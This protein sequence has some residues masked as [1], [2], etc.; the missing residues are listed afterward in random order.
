[1]HPQYE[2]WLLCPCGCLALSVNSTRP[3]AGQPHTLLCRASW[4][5][6][7]CSAL[8]ANGS[9]FRCSVALVPP[10]GACQSPALDQTMATRNSAVALGTE[11]RQRPE[12]DQEKSSRNNTGGS[13]NAGPL[14]RP[15]ASLGGRY[16]S[17]VLVRMHVYLYVCLRHANTSTLITSMQQSHVC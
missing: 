6:G 4:T 12:L 9:L 1:M 3:Y 15:V 5:Y 7:A 17:F 10:S 13:S 8:T 2:E 11:V 14:L 16:A